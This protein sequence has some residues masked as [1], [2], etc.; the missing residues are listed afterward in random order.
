MAEPTNDMKAEDLVLA[1]KYACIE[2][3][4][5]PDKYKR[6]EMNELRDQLIKLVTAALNIH[7]REG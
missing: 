6:Q 1:F 4:R 7:E 5:N 3:S 2:H